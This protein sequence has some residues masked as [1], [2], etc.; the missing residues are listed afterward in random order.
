M[1]KTAINKWLKANGFEITAMED[2][3]FY[4]D[5]CDCVVYYAHKEADEI[6]R[7]FYSVG[8]AEGMKVDCGIEV[9]SFLH[10]VGHIE[11][12]CD[13]EEDEWEEIEGEKAELEEISLTDE[14]EANKRYFYILDEITATRW[15]IDYINTHEKEIEILKKALDK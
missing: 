10:E 1:S 12:D 3:E 13:I 5:V 2:N 14:I 15:A 11:T 8:K 4:A 6:D 9:F 7:L